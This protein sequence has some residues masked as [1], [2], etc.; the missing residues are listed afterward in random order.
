MKNILPPVSIENFIRNWNHRDG[1]T[2][3]P[4]EQRDVREFGDYFFLLFV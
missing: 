1:K 3:I 2:T 4:N